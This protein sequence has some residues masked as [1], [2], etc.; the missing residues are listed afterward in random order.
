[1]RKHLMFGLSP[2]WKW[3]SSSGQRRA[4][5]P[6]AG[7]RPR[8][9]GGRLSLEALEDRTVLSVSFAPAVSLPVGLRPESIVTA[10]LNNDGKQDIVVLN[11][12]Q[13]RDFQ[14][15][16]SVLL[17]NGDGSF[18]P[19]ITT[20]L[21]PGA[22][23]VAAGDFNNDGQL[24]LAVA[25]RLNDVVE[26]LRGNGDGTFQDNPALLPISP[27]GFTLPSV[28]VA[29]GDFLHNGALGIAVTSGASNTV[30]VFVGNGDGTFQD[31]VDYAVGFNPQSV[32]A[33]DL[34]NGQVDL[35][36]ANHD[37][38]DVSVLLGNG[39]GTF[40]PA[41][42]IDVKT[43]SF[44]E[45]SHPLTL[46]AGDVNGDG[47]PDLLVSQFV[48]VDAGETILT[49]L[50]G[51]G[52]GTFQAPVHTNA[53]VDRFGLTVADFDGDGKLDV[54]VEEL[55]NFFPG[56]ADV[57]LGNG[58]GT[59]GDPHVFRTGGDAGFGVAAADFNGDG[60]PDLAVANTFSNDVRVLLN[61]S[62]G[63]AAGLLQGGFETPNV[64]TG[65]F[66]AF[67]YN[68]S[69]SAWTFSGSAGVAGNGSG[70]TGGNPDAP[71]G[72]QVAFLQAT[73]SFSQ[74][75]NLA[76]GT[77]SLSFLAAQRANFQAGAQTF[78]VLVD[79]AVV[80][81]F[82]PADTAYSALTTDAFTVAAGAHTIQ[83][84]GLNPQ[85]GDN[86]AFVDNVQLL[87]R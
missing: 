80:G 56:A 36:V 18:R 37:S 61:T 5:R 72:S 84:V 31:R 40:Q 83:F 79:G 34:G 35:V 29:V 81:T 33:V 64:G 24:D 44:G 76:A 69:G 73:G 9:A 21:L 45:D 87:A 8:P 57:L 10:D 55:D 6:P 62:T 25:N 65:S 43:Q 4:T 46:L 17:G 59:F 75:V 39:D 38:S 3:L 85:G 70:F 41:Q 60:R 77:Y 28:S 7:S 23:S 2:V 68:P 19:A 22:I 63:A 58:D 16:V 49:V 48:G 53:G 12:G 13:F 54:A 78:Q 74:T 26:V 67:Q 30:G 27:V 1:M 47:K 11:Q 66:G 52:D 50:P 42:N 20:G 86:T 82:T 51:N 71:D 15:S 32:A 14:S